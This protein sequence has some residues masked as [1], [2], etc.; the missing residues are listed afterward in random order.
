MRRA[1]IGVAVWS[2]TQRSDP[3][4]SPPSV[5]SSRRARRARLEPH[6]LE[7]RAGRDDAHPLA[8][9][10]PAPARGRL[11]AHGHRVALAQQA[12]DVRLRRVRR[13]AAERHLVRVAAVPRRQREIEVARGGRGVLEEH[14]V[15]VAEAEEEDGPAVLRLDAEILG[16]ERPLASSRPALPYRLRHGATHTR[17]A[18]HSASGPARGW[19]GCGR[20]CSRPTAAWPPRFTCTGSS[21]SS[22]RPL[23][24]ARPTRARPPRWSSSCEA[25]G[26]GSTASPLGATR[27]TSALPADL[28]RALLAAALRAAV[29]VRGAGG[30]GWE[31]RGERGRGAARRRRGRGGGGRHG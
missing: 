25:A 23:A 30:A 15:E 7:A 20:S 6:L 24:Q 3:R 5:R 19:P 28:P 10:E 26:N 14:L 18:G 21:A 2:S 12:R 4:R 22:P 27:R 31:A 8:L 11:L 16:E 1:P 29:G 17:S 9:H 13:E